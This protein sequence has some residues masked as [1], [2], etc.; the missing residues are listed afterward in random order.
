MAKQP[1]WS[2]YELNYVAEN[3]IKHGAKH[4]SIALGRSVAGVSHKV[5]RLFIKVPRR[6]FFKEKLQTIN[7]PSVTYI[8][9]LLWADGH[10][11]KFGDALRIMASKEDLDEVFSHFCE[12]GDWSNKK[13]KKCK[14]SWKD[15]SILTCCNADVLSFFKENDYQEKSVKAPTKI[16]SKIPDHLK[17]YFWRGYFDGDGGFHL[18]KQK[19]RGAI[20]TFSG[21]YNQDWFEHSSLLDSLGIRTYSTIQIISKKGHKSSCV[22]FCNKI[23][24]ANFLDYI[25]QDKNFKSFSRKT[26]KFL[27]F[28]EKPIGRVLEKRK[29]NPSTVLYNHFRG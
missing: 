14:Q 27:E 28:T 25:Y 6:I 18:K 21:H 10:L 9:G 19:T 15:I 29:L 4:C 13:V 17:H 22:S 16:L 1:K 26:K 7:S 20:L 8:L 24:A 2:E 5:E 23:D 3:Y 12:L 11:S